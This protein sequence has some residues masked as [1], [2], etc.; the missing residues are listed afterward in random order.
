[1][2]LMCL[3]YLAPRR[4]KMLQ[5]RPEMEKWQTSKR[6]GCFHHKMSI[7]HYVFTTFAP[8]GLAGP[9]RPG[10]APAQAG[11][12]PARLGPRPA[13]AWPSPARPGRGPDPGLAPARPK[14]GPAWPSLASA[15]H[16]PGPARPGLAGPGPGPAWSL[17]ALCLFPESDERRVLV[18]FVF[19]R[20]R[21]VRPGENR[22]A[23]GPWKMATLSAFWPV[24][25]SL[26]KD[27]S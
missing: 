25:G 19:R 10:L 2:Y 22:N 7:L 12:G 16:G 6:F 24:H 26:V 17:S 18:V 15:G 5:D 1:M 9:A 21:D 4:P 23:S 27:C 8:P 13:Q 3:I 20:G 11:P 14:P